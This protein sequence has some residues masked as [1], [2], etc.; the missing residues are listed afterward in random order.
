M[1]SNQIPNPTMTDFTCPGAADK[2]PLRR[3]YVRTMSITSAGGL[4]EERYRAYVHQ[5]C[6]L[7]NIK[8]G[9]PKLE[10][11]I[12]PPDK[13]LDEEASTVA[14]PCSSEPS[15]TLIEEFHVVGQT[16]LQLHLFAILYPNLVSVVKHPT[17][18]EVVIVCCFQGH[19]SHP[20]LVQK[21]M[22]ELLRLY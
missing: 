7:T 10:L 5:G 22:I 9:N 13:F 12:S 2:A 6:F 18:E 19:P 4:N 8:H 16:C 17:S 3:R 14:A 21:F 20:Y 15:N 1:K 11:C